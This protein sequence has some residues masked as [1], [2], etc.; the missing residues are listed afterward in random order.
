MKMDSLKAEENPRSVFENSLVWD[1]E[2]L[3]GA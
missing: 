2:M 3:L 1:V